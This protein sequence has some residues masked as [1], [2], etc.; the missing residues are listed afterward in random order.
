MG[1]IQLPIFSPGKEVRYQGRYYKID[2]VSISGY[3][4]KV[5]LIDYHGGVPAEDIVCEPTTFTLNRV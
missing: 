1:V 3:I 2:H 4:L 5:Y